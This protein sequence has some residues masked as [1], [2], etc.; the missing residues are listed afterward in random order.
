MPTFSIGNLCY[1]EIQNQSPV[2]ISET[3]SEVAAAEDADA[4][5]PEF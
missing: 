3:G 2:D 5:M 1:D 4:N